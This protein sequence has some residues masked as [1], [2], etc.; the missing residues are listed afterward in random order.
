MDKSAVDSKY[1]FHTAPAESSPDDE[2]KDGELNKPKKPL[3]YFSVVIGVVVIVGLVYMS[4]ISQALFY[5]RTQV[6]IFQRGL[7]SVINEKELVI[8]IKVFV[9]KNDKGFGSSRS[10]AEIEQMIKNAS[11]IWKQADIKLS[12]ED[13]VNVSASRDEMA[14]FLKSPQSF[15]KT[16]DGYDY[17]NINLFLMRSLIGMEN[18]N[19]VAFPGIRTVAVADFTSVYDFRVF[20]HEVGHV[21][22]LGHTRNDN[23]LLMYKG[24]NGFEI[25]KDEALSAHNAAYDLAPMK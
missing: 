14:S 9:F 3:R 2:F 6:G 1:E 22:G 24:A 13:V 21:L 20:A 11:E 17:N 23:G 16:L 15:I 8:P 7:K 19:G 18:V 4:G 25:T 12:L 5:K 10:S